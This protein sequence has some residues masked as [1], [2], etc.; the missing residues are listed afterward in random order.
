MTYGREILGGLELL[1]NPWMYPLVGGGI[2]PLDSLFTKPLLRY[3]RHCDLGQLLLHLSWCSSSWSLPCLRTGRPTYQKQHPP[4]WV[5]PFNHLVL[6]WRLGWY[7]HSGDRWYLDSWGSKSLV[8]LNAWLTAIF[9]C[10][11]L[12]LVNH[13]ISLTLQ[14]SSLRRER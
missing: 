5:L 2:L 6:L 10:I 9:L 14:L 8:F 7:F 4:I 3:H 12:Y 11:F 13:K 1:T